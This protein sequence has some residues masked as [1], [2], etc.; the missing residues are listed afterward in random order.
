M[1]YELNRFKNRKVRVS[2]LNLGVVKNTN[3]FKTARLP[4]EVEHALYQ[5]PVLEPTDIEETIGFLLSLPYGI[6]VS[7]MNIRATGAD[8]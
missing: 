7:D 2:N 8:V 5:N 4:L 3:I 1:R 6:N